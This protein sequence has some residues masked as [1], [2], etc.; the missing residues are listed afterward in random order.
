MNSM[1]EA[2]KIAQLLARHE[3]IKAQINALLGGGKKLG[4]GSENLKF[5]RAT[6][7]LRPTERRRLKEVKEQKGIPAAIA[8]A[9]KLKKH[10]TN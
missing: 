5:A 7:G 6:K 1:K 4:A 3:A 10:A 8:E 2:K 9:E